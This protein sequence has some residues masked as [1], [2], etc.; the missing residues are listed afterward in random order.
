VFVRLQLASRRYSPV[1]RPRLVGLLSLPGAPMSRN[2]GVRSC[3]VPPEKT[4]TFG[5][6]LL[7]FCAAFIGAVLLFA[8]I[9]GLMFLAQILGDMLT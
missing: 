2:Y 3:Y 7:L 4:L 1:D 9:A 8:L 5:E 6:R